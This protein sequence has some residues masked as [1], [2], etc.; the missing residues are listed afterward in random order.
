M[1]KT[2]KLFG[3]VLGLTAGVW[4]ANKYFYSTSHQTQSNEDK[5]L[6]LNQYQGVTHQKQKWRKEPKIDLW[7]LYFAHLMLL[8]IKQINIKRNGSILNLEAI[9][10]YS[11]VST[12]TKTWTN[13][14]TATFILKVN[15]FWSLQQVP[16]LN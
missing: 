7:Y 10:N 2:T 9:S 15:A 11:N 1:S 12:L 5:V 8:W 3:T 13:A 14:L 4:F 16:L 6:P